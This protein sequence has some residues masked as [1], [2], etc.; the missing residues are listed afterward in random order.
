MSFFDVVLEPLNPIFQPVVD[1]GV[2]FVKLVTLILELLK[3]APKLLSLLTILTDPVKVIKDIVFG[4][5]TGI[6]MIFD[7]VIDMLFGDIRKAMGISTEQGSNDGEQNSSKQKKC[8][9]P[10]VTKLLLLILCPPL[11]LL[12]ERGIHSILYVFICCILTYFYYFPGLIYASLYI[13][14]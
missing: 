9:P 11:A 10:S 1:I 14:C 3:M 6:Y 5:S 4:I 13:L 8:I 2:F 12:L 7:A